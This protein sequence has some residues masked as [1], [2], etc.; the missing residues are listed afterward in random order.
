MIQKTQAGKAG[1]S[2]VKTLIIKCADFRTIRL[3]FIKGKVT[4][5]ADGQP[6]CNVED[7]AEE[8]A[9]KEQDTLS[10]KSTCECVVKRLMNLVICV[11]H[12][13]AGATRMMRVPVVMLLLLMMMMM[14]DDD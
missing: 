5:R 14:I 3:T 1:F 4:T 8:I 7:G 10:H 6:L 2:D 13:F 12:F 11:I 9:L